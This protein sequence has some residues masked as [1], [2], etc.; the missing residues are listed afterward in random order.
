M[1]LIVSL[2]TAKKRRILSNCSWKHHHHNRFNTEMGEYKNMA[3]FCLQRAKI[4]SL[5][6]QRIPEYIMHNL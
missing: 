5:A 1:H 6:M 4:R 2:D 3:L